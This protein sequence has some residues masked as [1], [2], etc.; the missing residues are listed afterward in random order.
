MVTRKTAVK[1]A[2]SFVNDCEL[3]GLTFHKVLLFGSFAK[4]MGH[5]WSDIDLLL[6]SDQFGDNIF[7]NLKLYSKINIKYP[8][9]E[10]HPYPT[11][12]YK[13]GN[14]FINEIIK[15]SIEIV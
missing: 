14:D 7:E 6:V 1:T 15:Q 2:Q 10:T 3:N 12:Y 13:E 9:I 5:E 4:N 11:S 8:I